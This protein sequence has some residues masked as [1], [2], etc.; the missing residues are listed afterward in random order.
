MS[1]LRSIIGSPPRH[2]KLKNHIS[3]G[4]GPTEEIRAVYERFCTKVTLLSI[5]V[6]KIGITIGLVAFCTL[7]IFK[8]P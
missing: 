6:V 2:L 1:I 3:R 4:S 5:Y 7:K 8:T